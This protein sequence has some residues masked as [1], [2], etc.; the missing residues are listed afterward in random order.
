MLE[1]LLKVHNSADGW[2][3]KKLVNIHRKRGEK[4]PGRV[5]VF[6]DEKHSSK[7]ELYFKLTATQLQT[8]EFWKRKPDPFFVV[9]RAQ[10]IGTDDYDLEEVGFLAL[11]VGRLAEGTLVINHSDEIDV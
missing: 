1:F 11:G 4:H 9:S 6:A 10:V 2:L 5:C 7:L 3:R 8:G